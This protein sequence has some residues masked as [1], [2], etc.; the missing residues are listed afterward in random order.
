VLNLLEGGGVDAGPV[1][2]D[3]L[4]QIA[5]L[6]VKTM[7]LVVKDVAAGNR[8]AVQ[9]PDQ[10]FLAQGQGAEPV[11]VQLDHGRFAD[12]LEQ[13]LA[14]WR[15]EAAAGGRGVVVHPVLGYSS[16]RPT[17]VC[18]DIRRQFIGRIQCATLC[19]TP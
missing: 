7:A 14:V 11:G 16:G 6:E 3:G 10:R 17:R 18:G 12:A 5:H 8:G 13:V 1:G 9:V 2:N 19:P 4:E 15:A